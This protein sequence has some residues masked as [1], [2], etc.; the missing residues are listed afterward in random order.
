MMAE[1]HLKIVP[2]GGRGID[3]QDWPWVHCCQS[4][5]TGILPLK[6]IIKNNGAR[7]RLLHIHTPITT[8]KR[9]LQSQVKAQEY[10]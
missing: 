5:V 2:G 1:I 9:S 4:Q 10:F 6:I 3:G 7:K 8:G